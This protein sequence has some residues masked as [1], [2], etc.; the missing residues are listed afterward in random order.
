MFWP[1]SNRRPALTN[2]RHAPTESCPYPVSIAPRPGFQPHYYY[3]CY[4]HYY[5]YHYYY[6]Y[7]H[8][9][10]YSTTTT[11]TTTNY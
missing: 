2:R 6:Y 1:K 5:Y 11:T 7:H 9:Y 10:Y 3:Y 4:H 8:Y